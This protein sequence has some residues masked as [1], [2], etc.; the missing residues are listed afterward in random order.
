MATDL[1]YIINHAKDEY[2]MLD[3]AYLGLVEQLHK[4]L[5]QVKGYIVLA[6]K[7]DMPAKT[8]LH[9]VFCYEDW[10][11]VNCLSTA[12]ICLWVQHAS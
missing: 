6:D 9:P 10:L 2:I 4:H 7:E 8:S 1:E 12:C 3:V 11:Q 5:P